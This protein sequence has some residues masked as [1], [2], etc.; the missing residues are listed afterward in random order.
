MSVVDI[1]LLRWLCQFIQLSNIYTGDASSFRSVLHYN[2]VILY[3]YILN[4]FTDTRLT[5]TIPLPSTLSHTLSTQ[6]P[7]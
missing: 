7:P 2:T 5:L 4:K 3:K 6:L 1:S